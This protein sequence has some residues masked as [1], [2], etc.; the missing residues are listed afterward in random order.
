MHSH[1][2]LIYE[3]QQEQFATIIPFIRVGLSRGEKCVYIVDENT[4]A[5]VLDAMHAAGIEIDSA[6]KKGAFVITGKQETYLQKGYFNPEVMMRFLK[7]AADS[8]K[9]EGFSALRVTGEMTWALGGDPGS[10]RLAEYESKLNYFFPEND[11]VAICQYNITKFSAEV[12]MNII[13]THPLVI[14]RNIVC[15]NFYYIPPDEF[16]K[17]ERTSLMVKHLLNNLLDREKTEEALRRSEEKYR[18]LAE[19]AQDAIFIINRNF[20]FEY[21]ND[22]IAKNIL[23]IL[24]QEIIGKLLWNLFPPDIAEGYKQNLMRVFET[25]QSIH[26]EN[27]INLYGREV[28]QDAFLIPLK[29]ETGEVAAV[30]GIARDITKRKL[31]EEKLKETLKELTQ[32]NA[33]LE[34]F[35]HMSAHDLQEPLR[36]VSCYVQMLEKRYKGKLDPDADEIIN[37]AAEGAQRMSKMITDLLIFSSLNKQVFESTD[38]TAVLERAL[39]NLKDVIMENKAGITCDTMPSSILVDK[40]QFAQLFQNLIDNAIKFRGKDSP[41]IHVSAEKKGSEWEFSVS[42]NGI[43]IEPQYFERIFIMFHRLYNRTKYPGTGIGLAMCKK[44]VER[45]GGRMWVESE[46]GKGSTFHFTIPIKNLNSK[47]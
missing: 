39:S 46:V 40:S 38:F 17:P 37:Y 24:P 44:I 47:N 20:S 23:R 22:F 13:R 10:D 8:A 6:I 26:D 36:M 29:S 9:T 35:T 14:F 25:G 28:W 31:A 27:K 11:V 33:E 21:V 5:T 34:Q 42:D 2:C 30:L 1:L 19:A 43:G 32:S 15:R 12:I 3:T 16:F 41:R 7:E 4:T 18:T 45:H